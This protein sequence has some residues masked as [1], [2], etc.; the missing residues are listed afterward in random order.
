MYIRSFLSN[1][2]G[3]YECRSFNYKF[4]SLANSSLLIKEVG[5]YHKK[6]TLE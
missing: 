5:S 6:A 4:S 2:D 1:C 3:P